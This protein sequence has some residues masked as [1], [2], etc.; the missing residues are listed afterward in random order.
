MVGHVPGGLG[1]VAIAASVLLVL[2]A[3]DDLRGAPAVPSEG[4]RP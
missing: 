4:D 1:Y 3:W 2:Q